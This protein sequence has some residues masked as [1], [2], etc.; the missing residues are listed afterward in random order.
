[1]TFDTN[2]ILD[3]ND[4]DQTIFRIFK[5]DRLRQLMCSNELVLVN[6]NKLDDPFENFFLRAIA[7]GKD[8]TRYSLEE[9]QNAWYVQ[10]WTFE[11]ERDALWRIYSPAKDGVRVSTTI[12]R[13][14][15]Y[16][17]NGKD[18]FNRL[19]YFIGKVSYKSRVEIEALMQENSFWNFAMGGQ[20]H[21]FARLLCIKRKDFSHEDEVRVMFNDVEHKLGEEG[22]Y[23]QHFEYDKVFDSICLDPRLDEDEFGQLKHEFQ[24]MGCTLPITQSELYRVNFDP[25]KLI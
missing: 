11:K 6:P 3:I 10:C 5:I 21:G 13:L 17:W 22:L 9:L 1:M 24:C 23:R 12:R 18:P 15:S 16:I 25:I 2:N 19:R 4:V 20:N 14:F 7:V 8:V